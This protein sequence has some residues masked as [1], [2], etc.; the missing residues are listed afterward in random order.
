M[1][2]D[3]RLM[4]KEAGK[5]AGLAALASGKVELMKARKAT[6]LMRARLT[7]DGRRVFG[8]AEMHVKASRFL[9]TVDTHTMDR[10]NAVIF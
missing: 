4:D 6:E 8:C 2:A 9:S 7:G 1:E 3:A 10:S 5:M